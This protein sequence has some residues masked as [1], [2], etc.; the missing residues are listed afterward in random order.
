MIRARVAAL[1]AA[2]PARLQIHYAV[3]A[4]PYPPLLALMSELVDG[5][6]VASLGELRLLREAGSTPRGSALPGPASATANSPRR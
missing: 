1:R 2:M 5:F 4:N 6:D 3:K